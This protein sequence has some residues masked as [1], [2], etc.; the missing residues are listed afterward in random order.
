M[1][2]LILTLSAA[3]LFSLGAMAQENDADSVNNNA[4]NQ[5]VTPDDKGVEDNGVN[6]RLES[7]KDDAQD[8]DAN[9][10][11]EDNGINDKLE[12]GKDEAQQGA[13]KAGDEMK[14]TGQEIEQG[15]EKAGD[16]MEET[17]QE[18][19]QGVEKTGNEI[20]SGARQTADSVESDAAKAADETGQAIESGAEK[21]GDAIQS[22][23]DQAKD[24]VEGTDDD[25][26]MEK[27]VQSQ[28]T[29]VDNANQAV[30]S[31][32]GSTG[33]DATAT[34]TASTEEAMSFGPDVEIVEDKEGPQ[35]QVVY[36]INDELFYVDRDQ[37]QLVKVSESDLR[38]AKDHAVIHNSGEMNATEQK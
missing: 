21:A 5:A 30:D 24:A 28:D 7:G 6:D 10:G 13:E 29:N 9:K 8:D 25:V 27:N 26:K 33:T 18:I 14:E 20:Q 23:A 16:E 1:K 32:S 17:G 22:G 36:K 3:V 38:D 11:S 4:S 35:N 37:Q 2:K 19:E 15:A 34:G 31:G 12:D